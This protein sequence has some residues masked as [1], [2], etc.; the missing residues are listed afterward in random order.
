MY[1]TNPMS[2]QIQHKVEEGNDMENQQIQIGSPELIKAPRSYVTIAKDKDLLNRIQASSRI[3]DTLKEAV[4]KVK[5]S[6][7]LPGKD[8]ILEWEMND[9]LLWYKGFIYVPNDI[10]L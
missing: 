6:K 8:V 7:H 1:L 9:G 5:S 10:A 3:D 2:R 4:T